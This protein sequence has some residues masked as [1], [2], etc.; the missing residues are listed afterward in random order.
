MPRMPLQDVARVE[1]TPRPRMNL[2]N[3][4]LTVLLLLLVQDGAQN[5]YMWM[6]CTHSDHV[7]C[8]YLDRCSG[9]IPN[10]VAIA[11]G[12]ARGVALTENARKAG[13]SPDISAISAV[14]LYVTAAAARRWFLCR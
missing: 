11:K 1:Y 13:I 8:I 5:M 4:V 3:K 14:A 12:F 9:H 7:R 2:R 6:R 10:T